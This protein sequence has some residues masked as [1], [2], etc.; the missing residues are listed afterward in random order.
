MKEGITLKISVIKVTSVETIQPKAL[1]KEK[2]NT[3]N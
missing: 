1:G 2:L 3:E